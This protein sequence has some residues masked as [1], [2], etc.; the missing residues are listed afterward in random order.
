MIL[1]RHW[2]IHYGFTCRA[3]KNKAWFYK[4]L[5]KNSCLKR[6][7]QVKHTHMTYHHIIHMV[8]VLY[9]DNICSC[10]H[11]VAQFQVPACST[12]IIWCIHPQSMSVIIHYTLIWLSVFVSTDQE[13]KSVQLKVYCLTSMHDSFYT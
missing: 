13:L 1:D 5:V 4:N 8:C 6:I 2:T 9:T 12:F 11:A 7:T 3:V 10:M